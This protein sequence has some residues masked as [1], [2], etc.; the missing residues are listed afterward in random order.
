MGQG[1][2]ELPKELWP[3]LGGSALGKNRGRFQG[4]S[5]AVPKCRDMETRKK[6]KKREGHLN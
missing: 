1:D 4:G 6:I 3:T 2:E 5:P